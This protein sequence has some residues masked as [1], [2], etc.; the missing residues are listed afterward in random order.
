MGQIL[1]KLVGF[2]IFN[3]VTQAQLAALESAATLARFKSGAFV[4]EKNREALKFYLISSGRIAIELYSPE[5]GPH[6][7]QELGPGEILGTSWI[8]PPYRWQFDARAVTETE[9]IAFDAHRVRELLDNDHDLGYEL[10]KRF[11]I[12]I[13]GRLA[14]AQNEMTR[15]M[16]T[17]SNL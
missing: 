10:M 15:F 3:G 7:L 5:R 16:S 14:A 13:S 8:C 9:V 12:S 2:D 17:P 6:A 4:I 11:F 1:E